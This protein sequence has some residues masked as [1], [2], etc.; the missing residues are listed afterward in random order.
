M[1]FYASKIVGLLLVPS[2]LIVLIGLLGVV[3][4][5]T[6]F[7]RAGRRLAATSILLITIVGVLPIGT[8]LTRFLE[9]RFPPWNGVG[10]PAGIIILGGMIDPDLSAIRGEPMLGD[11]T[12]RLI[13]IATLARRYPDARIVFSGGNGSVV[14]G[15]ASEA[16]VARGIFESFGIARERILLEDRSRTTAENARLTAELVKPRPGE[17]WLLVTSA[18]H[19]PR[20]IAAFRH[21][22]FPVVAYPVDWQTSGRSDDYW[23]STSIV[24]G[25]GSLDLASHEWQGLLAYWLSGRTTELLPKP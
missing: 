3:L 4:M 22:S 20:A 16:E 8:A 21:A 14:P 24:G 5:P 25:L 13:V 15:G 11:S 17:L 19:M 12:E 23:P 6:R 2:H 18:F 9:D 10:T 7:A 1:F